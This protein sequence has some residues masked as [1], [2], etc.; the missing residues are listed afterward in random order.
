MR[1]IALTLSAI[2]LTAIAASGCNNQLAQPLPGPTPTSANPTP[3]YGAAGGA[4]VPATTPNA[5]STIPVT[6]K[7]EGAGGALVAPTTPNA[8]DQTTQQKQEKS[9]YFP[10]PDA[11]LTPANPNSR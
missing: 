6:P 5:G 7:G 3:G 9:G 10:S 4:L 11:P 1:F 2:G 8:T